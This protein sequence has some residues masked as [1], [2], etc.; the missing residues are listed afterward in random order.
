[1]SN[2][3]IDISVAQKRLLQFPPNKENINPLWPSDTIRWHRTRSA[4]AHAPSH[5]LNQYELLVPQEVWYICSH[6]MYA[7]SLFITIRGNEVT[8]FFCCQNDN[9][10]C[11]S[12]YF[13]EVPF[14]KIVPMYMMY[15]ICFLPNLFMGLVRCKLC[16]CQEL[17]LYTCNSLLPSMFKKSHIS[18]KVWDKITYMLKYIQ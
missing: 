4:L 7:H 16:D 9:A 12:L 17:C 8:K 6:G 1:M 13:S 18:S 2:L 14:Q 15:L 3:K 10:G 11:A 5:Y